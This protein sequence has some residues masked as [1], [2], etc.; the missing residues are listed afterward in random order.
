MADQDRAR[1]GPGRDNVRD[2]APVTPS[3]GTARP[4]GL[5]FDVEEGT[6]LPVG[7]Q[8]PESPG[9]APAGERGGGVGLA[10]PGD[11]YQEEEGPDGSRA[12]ER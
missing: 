8:A 9:A 10:L 6:D 3:R 11:H 2:P 4:E 5:A 1:T 7:D 12:A